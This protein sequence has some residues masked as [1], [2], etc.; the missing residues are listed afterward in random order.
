MDRET[1]QRFLDYRERHSYFGKKTTLLG[2]AEFVA[3]DAEYNALEDKGD[4]RDDEEEARYVELA[5]V[6]FRD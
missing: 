2:N 3:L 4:K 6:L 5:K 1:H